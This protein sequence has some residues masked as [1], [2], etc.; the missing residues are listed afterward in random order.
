MKTTFR[1]IFTLLSLFVFATNQTYIHIEITDQTDPIAFKTIG[2][3]GTFGLMTNME[4]LNSIFNPSEIETQTNFKGNF[5]SQSNK[6]YLWNCRLW[7]PAN[8]NVAVLCT[9]DDIISKEER[10][11]FVL[12]YGEIRKGNEYIIKIKEQ[13]IISILI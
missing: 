3:K 12:T 5:I 8:M 2:Q 13:I 1:I 7:D 11:N 9:I 10:K 6:T 4:N